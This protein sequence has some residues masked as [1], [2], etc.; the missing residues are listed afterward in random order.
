MSPDNK[1]TATTEALLIRQLW[2]FFHEWKKGDAVGKGTANSSHVLFTYIY[3][4]GDKTVRS[5]GY[6]VE[7][8]FY[9]AFSHPP[10]TSDA[11]HS[12]NTSII[13]ILESQPVN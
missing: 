1:N 6:R 2:V 11:Y 5:D 10:A 7:S 8:T 9:I 3:E 4:K 12:Y 13:A